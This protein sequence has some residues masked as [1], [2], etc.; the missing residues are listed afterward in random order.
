[1]RIDTRI[2][3]VS[4]GHTFHPRRKMKITMAVIV[5][6][7]VAICCCGGLINYLRVF[8]LH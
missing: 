2:G 7:V 1:M 8:G 5:G 3:P 6:I 4:V